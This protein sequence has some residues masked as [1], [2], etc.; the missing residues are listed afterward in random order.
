MSKIVIKANM[1]TPERPRNITRE[2]SSEISEKMLALFL[3]SDVEELSDVARDIG[4]VGKPIFNEVQQKAIIHYS[5]DDAITL[6]IELK[7]KAV[8]AG[9]DN[10]KWLTNLDTDN[11]EIKITPGLGSEII[12]VKTIEKKA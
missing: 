8:R 4:I 12:F 10:K 1:G 2:I 7:K 5:I 9:D 11:T 3:A 6:L